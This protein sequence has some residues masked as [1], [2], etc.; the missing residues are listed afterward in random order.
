MVKKQIKGR[1][2]MNYK[3]GHFNEFGDEFIINAPNTPRP[4]DNFLYNDSCYANVHQTG[5]GCFDYQIDGKEGATHIDHRLRPL[6]LF[7][8]WTAPVTQVRMLPQKFV[9]L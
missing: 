3:Y 4:F 8:G 7:K 6:V 1:L 2:N 5:I 9:K